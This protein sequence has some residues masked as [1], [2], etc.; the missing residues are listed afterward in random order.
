MKYLNKILLI[1]SFASAFSFAPQLKAQVLDPQLRNLVERTSFGASWADMKKAQELGYQGYLDYQLNPKGIKNGGIRRKA[2]DGEINLDPLTANQRNW[3]ANLDNWA[4]ANM[5]YA[6]RQLNE[7]MTWFWD[8]HFNTN[9]RKMLRYTY[10]HDCRLNVREDNLHNLVPRVD[11]NNFDLIANA[12]DFDIMDSSEFDTV[13]ITMSVSPKIESSGLG[14][15]VRDDIIP[16]EYKRD[17]RYFLKVDGYLEEINLIK[18]GEFHTY[19]IPLNGERW[20]NELFQMGIRF[21]LAQKILDSDMDKND[22]LVKVESFKLISSA[23]PGNT[24]DFIVRTLKSELKENHFFRRKALGNFYDLLKFSARSQSMLI[25]LDNYASKKEN[26]NQNYARELLELHT[27]GQDAGYTQIDVE[28]AAKVFT[29][30][31]VRNNHFYFDREQHNTD[32]VQFSFMDG[33]IY[34]NRNARTGLDLLRDLASHPKTAEFICS[35]LITLFVN[36]TD[37]ARG[38]S[39]V[40]A[41]KTTFMTNQ[42][43]D[44]Q[45]AQVLR[46]ILTSDE[47]KNSSNQKIQTPVEYAIDKIRKFDNAAE[48]SRIKNYA[49]SNNYTLFK[50]PV[51]TGYK[52]EG[53][54]WLNSSTQLISRINFNRN[55]INDTDNLEYFKTLLTSETDGSA[56]GVLDFSIDYFIGEDL[57]Q[58]SY[59]ILLETLQPDGFTLANR[60]WQIRS[61]LRLLLDTPEAHVH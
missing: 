31:T 44:D 56:K 51:P 58:V 22:E 26:P 6:N 39:L 13:E 30:W 7:L 53:K 3:Q 14:F 37:R 52:E 2:N 55:L 1:A 57:P 23:K 17:N 54:F 47:F 16:D 40:Q 50:M 46:T 59:D 28:S 8:N 48:V 42:D 19:T 29:G 41:C 25:Y 43:A 18:D 38:D 21:N 4:L 24:V 49:N 33:K 10:G 5:T 9:L 15:R 12:Y 60:D 27:M 35:K 11:R 45:I 32:P 36:D 61:M 20:K 34:T